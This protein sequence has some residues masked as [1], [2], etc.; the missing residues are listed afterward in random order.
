MTINKKLHGITSDKLSQTMVIIADLY[1]HYQTII[2][3]LM[4]SVGM[5]LILFSSTMVVNSNDCVSVNP[6][7]RICYKKPVLSPNIGETV[8]F[9]AKPDLNHTSIPTN[10][11][12]FIHFL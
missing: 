10:P 11:Y 4:M 7:K 2:S 6:I 9:I 12:P 5:I 8:A 1:E 3:I